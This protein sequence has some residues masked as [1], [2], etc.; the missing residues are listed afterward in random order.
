LFAIASIVLL[1]LRSIDQD[2]ANYLRSDNAFAA[3][4]WHSLWHSSTWKIF[5]QCLHGK[6]CGNYSTIEILFLFS[7]MTQQVQSIAQNAHGW[8]NHH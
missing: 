2:V 8:C 5:Y 4:I 1:L 7:Q 6:H 3:L